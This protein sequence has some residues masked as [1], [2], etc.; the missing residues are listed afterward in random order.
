[1]RFDG[2]NSSFGTSR[3]ERLT[4]LNSIRKLNKNGL[5]T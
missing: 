5:P 2:M 1:V 3:E 4:E